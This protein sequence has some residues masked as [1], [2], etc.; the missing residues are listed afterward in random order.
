MAVPKKI[1]NGYEFDKNTPEDVVN[2]L[3]RYMHDRDIRIRLFYGDTK[4]GKDWCEEYGTMGYVGGS[5]GKVKIPLLIN[6]RNSWGGGAILTGSIVR[7][8]IDK[9]DVYR[10]P[11]YHIGKVEVKATG[12][13]DLPYGVWIGGEN[14][15]RFKTLIQAQKWAEFIKGNTNSKS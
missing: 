15:A 12:R 2:I 5:T 10:H 14:H 3:L 1:I 6:N 11:K 9:K 4:T 8:T 7:I 13:T